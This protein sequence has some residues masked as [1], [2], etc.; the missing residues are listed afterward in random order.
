[1]NETIAL[2]LKVGDK[3][4]DDSLIIVDEDLDLPGPVKGG[5]HAFIEQ[6]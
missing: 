3:T 5:Q 4:Q 6:Y 2:T 1:M